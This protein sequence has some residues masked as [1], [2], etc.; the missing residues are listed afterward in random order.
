MYVAHVQDPCLPHDS[1]L[2]DQRCRLLGA[3]K[4]KVWFHVFASYA[5]AIPTYLTLRPGLSDTMC[6]HEARCLFRSAASQHALMLT[7]LITGHHMPV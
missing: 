6:H 3:C 4:E 2:D 5:S 1:L 7:V